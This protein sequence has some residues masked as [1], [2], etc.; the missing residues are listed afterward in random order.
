M[1]ARASAAVAPS[2]SAHADC[3][4]IRPPRGTTPTEVSPSAR[5]TGMTTDAGLYPSAARKPARMGS[6]P[7][8]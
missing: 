6:A 4:E 2:R 3:P 7:P 8:W 1:V 5:V